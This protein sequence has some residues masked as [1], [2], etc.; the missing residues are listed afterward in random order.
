MQFR[1]QR[2]GHVTRCLLVRCQSVAGGAAVPVGSAEGRAFVPRVI[3]IA[4]VCRVERLGFIIFASTTRKKR[5]GGALAVG[6][7][8]VEKK[9]RQ[10]LTHAH[11]HAGSFSHAFAVTHALYFHTPVCRLACT[12]GQRRNAGK[13]D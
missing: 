10:G 12:S 9:R 2:Q 8:A 13:T 4:N 5:G 6:E 1:A 3:Y 7:R 11:N